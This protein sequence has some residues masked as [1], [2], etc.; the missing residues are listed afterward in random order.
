MKLNH[1]KNIEKLQKISSI[2]QNLDSKNSTKETKDSIESNIESTNITPKSISTIKHKTPS[3]KQLDSFKDSKFYVENKKDVYIS[4][5]DINGISLELI[6]RNHDKISKWC[7]PIYCLSYE[8]LNKAAKL[9]NLPI[10]NMHLE[11]LDSKGIDI[12]PGVASKESGEY[13]FKSFE[14]A[15]TLS[16]KHNAPLVTL[17]INKYAWNLAGIKYAGHTEYLRDRF[18]KE[19]IML[20]GNE[21]M[22]VALFTDHVPLE[23]VPK[24]IT[25]EKLSDFLQTFYECYLSRFYKDI[26]QETPIKIIESKENPNIDSIKSHLESKEKSDNVLK[27]AALNPK[28]VSRLL[29]SDFIESKKDVNIESKTHFRQVAILGL[30]P[31]AGDNGVL[32]TQDFIIK[33][34]ID[35][36]NARLK[37]DLFVGPLPPDCAFIPANRKKYKIFVAMYHDSGLAPLKALYFDNS[38]N[39]SLN[40]PILRV[41]PDHGTGYDIAY[42]KD[43][44]LNSQSYLEC[45]R[46][47]VVR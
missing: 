32:G 29:D 43:S 6:L 8:I 15:T 39:V 16:Q 20:L 24:M 2:S 10:P 37:F 34:C 12:T 7:K 18:K 13:S 1:I 25:L 4:C 21:N 14:L 22:Q 44:N 28:M 23:S 46:F 30:N 26:K 27:K 11:E 17:P 3:K 41:S 36:M 31:H 40:L 33:D 5:G 19:A 38:I 35:I 42:K 47:V 45:F 9:L